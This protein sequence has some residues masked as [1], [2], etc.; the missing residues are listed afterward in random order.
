M[1]IAEGALSESFID[2]DSRGMFHNAH[3]YCEL[4]ANAAPAAARYCAPRLDQGYELE[5]IRQRLRGAQ[6]W[7]QVMRGCGRAICTAFLIG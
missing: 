3:E 7:R 6:D 1:I 4:Y 5:M 2:D